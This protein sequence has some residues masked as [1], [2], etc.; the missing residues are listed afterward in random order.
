[1]LTTMP[2]FHLRPSYYVFFSAVGEIVRRIGK[3]YERRAHMRATYLAIISYSM[4]TCVP[5]A[6]APS[7]VVFTVCGISATVKEDADT[8]TTVKLTPSIATDPFGAISRCSL[9]GMEMRSVIISCSMIIFWIFPTASTCPETICPSSEPPKRNGRSRCTRLPGT[10][11]P[12]VVLRSVSG[13]YS[14]QNERASYVVTVEHIPCT[15]MLCPL[16]IFHPR[17]RVTHTRK[18]F[19][20]DTV[21]MI[22]AVVSMIP[23]N[24]ALFVITFLVSERS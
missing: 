20:V 15:A 10:N 12:A 17:G 24:I 16:C 8:S 6:Y 23:V 5:I 7:I 13:I 4:L 18:I 2:I 21:F 1:M 14:T 19:A 22:G 3:F 11:P 9:F